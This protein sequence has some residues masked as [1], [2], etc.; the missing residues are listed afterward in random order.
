[1]WIPYHRQ[2]HFSAYKK[3]RILEDAT[4]SF[5]MS[6]PNTTKLHREH[7]K[8]HNDTIE[9]GHSSMQGYRVHME[10][11]RIIDKMTD[12]EDHVF[13]AIMD[14]HAGTFAAHY[15]GKT[16][17]AKL[18]LTPEW[19]EYLQLSPQERTEKAELLSK[20][21]VKTYLNLDDDLRAY[22]DQNLMDDSGCTAVCA[23][24]TPSHIIVGS[25][26]DSRCVLG[27]G[28]QVI[29]FTED[30]KPENAEERERIQKAGGFVQYNRVNG[31]LAMSRALGDFR[32][33]PSDKGLAN[34]EYLVIAYP[35]ISIHK[36]TTE[37]E[38]LVLACDGVWD[39][40]T[41]DEAVAF[42]SSILKGDL[43]NE[44]VEENDEE[45][46]KIAKTL[47]VTALDAAEELID[48]ALQEGSTDNISAIVVKFSPPQ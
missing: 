8:F 4:S 23:L 5:F 12:L 2:P 40:L 30:H 15:T 42:V 24:I 16:L 22:K 39:V 18:E 43:I 48:L 32:Y 11:E 35:D 9:A 21:I 25:V 19:L 45:Q 20:A 46:V 36:R 10:D 1:M 31:E 27:S 33:K 7:V 14:G 44:I 17:K 29:S 34:H 37:D 3:P 13:V 6:K 41:N 28:T 26:G 38:I 47:T